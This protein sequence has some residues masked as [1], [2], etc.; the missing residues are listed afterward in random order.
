[1]PS[2]IWTAGADVAAVA[3]APAPTT[4]WVRWSA[5]AVLVTAPLI[6]VTDVEP[7]RVVTGLPHSFHGGKARYFRGT[8][9]LMPDEWGVVEDAKLTD[10]AGEWERRDDDGAVY[11]AG[12]NGTVYRLAMAFRMPAHR[13]MPEKGE[14]FP[15]LVRGAALTFT[16]FSATERWTM[17]GLR[18]VD[19]QARHYTDM[20]HAVPVAPEAMVPQ[21]LGAEFAV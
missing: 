15:Y 19:V 20:P 5:P 1:M 21:T 3:T 16:I 6:S 17:E 8:Y 9:G 11:G 4:V 2:P 10:S 13:A 14:Q 18:M 12:A 7:S